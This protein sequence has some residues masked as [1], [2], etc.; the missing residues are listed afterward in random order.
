MSSFI[1]MIL[2]VI[3]AIVAILELV[4]GMSRI[5]TAK[6]IREKRNKN[7]LTAQS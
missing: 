3:L 2:I 5:R 6:R 7:E 4:I 1:T